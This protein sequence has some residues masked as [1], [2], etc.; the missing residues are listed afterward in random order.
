M[1]ARDLTSL[2]GECFSLLL[3]FRPEGGRWL[4][5]T[6]VPGA[7]APFI[8]ARRAGETHGTVLFSCSV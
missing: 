4:P 3:T 5:G 7:Q 8:P 1:V 2:V 6:L